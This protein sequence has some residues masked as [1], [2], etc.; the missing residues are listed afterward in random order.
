MPE[1]PIL[2]AESIERD[3]F[4]KAEQLRDLFADFGTL[5]DVSLPNGNFPVL[6]VTIKPNDEVFAL[7]EPHA[8]NADYDR[9]RRV[10]LTRKGLG[11]ELSVIF[12]LGKVPLPP[13]KPDVV[14]N[15]KDEVAF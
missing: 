10:T 12:D 14:R 1:S 3:L 15:V 6:T 4:A 5:T 11:S 13:P 8:G 9:H 2:T 7:V